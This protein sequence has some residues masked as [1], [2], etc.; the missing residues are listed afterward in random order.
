MFFV[1]ESPR[2]LV[3]AGR[4]DL[5]ERI[6][7]R[8]GGA[9]YARAALGEIRETLATDRDARVDFSAVFDPH[10]RQAVVIGAVLAVFQ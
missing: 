8:V 9:A 10:L 1:S 6:L 2:W 5:C 4:D 3:R 7:A